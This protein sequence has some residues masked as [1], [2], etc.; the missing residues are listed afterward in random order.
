[1][2]LRKPVLL[3]ALLSLF[4]CLLP[5][6]AGKNVPGETQFVLTKAEN[7]EL[8][9]GRDVYGNQC[10]CDFA[11]LPKGDVLL[12]DTAANAVFTYSADGR[13]KATYSE[14][15]GYKLAGGENGEFYL[16]S[17][18]A[19][20]FVTVKNGV[21]ANRCKL[22]TSCGIDDVG[23]ITEIDYANEGMLYVQAEAQTVK[24]DVSGDKA[25]LVG[26]P[27]PGY[28]INGGGYYNVM[29]RAIHRTKNNG[30]AV[31][32][33]HEDGQKAVQ[34]QVRTLREDATFCGIRLLG[35]APGGGYYAK[36]FESL[37]GNKFIQT[38]LS[39]DPDLGTITECSTDLGGQDLIRGDCTLYA[40]HYGE[41]ELTIKP[42]ASW[43][44][45]SD[46]TS[47]F[48]FTSLQEG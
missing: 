29:L 35:K 20:E 18:A 27:L 45:T 28:R 7:S 19:S 47:H 40:M 25:A 13:L 31:T 11:V 15:N 33:Y 17:G 4:V 5:G 36:V 14:A 26:T 37:P 46:K 48:E 16:L 10:I 39:I 23:L 1:M 32:V 30:V 22:D 42:F 34:F 21:V 24:L 38:F 41:D 3:I 43:I 2:R 8:N 44:V 6:C 9:F 12:L